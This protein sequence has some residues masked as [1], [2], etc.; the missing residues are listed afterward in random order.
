MVEYVDVYKPTV[1]HDMCQGS[2]TRWTELLNTTM[3]PA[4]P[5]AVGQLVMGF[6]V[7]GQLLGRS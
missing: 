3:A 5:N 6:G 7:A 2:D 4:R 1:G